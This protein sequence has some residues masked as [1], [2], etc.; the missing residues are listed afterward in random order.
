MQTIPQIKEALLPLFNL[1]YGI[2][3]NASLDPG[4]NL[5]HNTLDWLFALVNA[6]LESMPDISEIQAIIGKDKMDE[7]V[8]EMKRFHEYRRTESLDK[9]W[10]SMPVTE[11][12]G[13]EA[14]QQLILIKLATASST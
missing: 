12:I 5:I 9:P 6:S 14:V 4:T 3:H 10:P 11:T 2:I 1:I 8:E 7:V 13:L